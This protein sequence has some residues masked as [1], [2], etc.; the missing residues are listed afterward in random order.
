MSDRVLDASVILAVLF[1]EP[2]GDPRYLSDGKAA[3]SAVNFAEVV[4]RL[5]VAGAD[6]AQISRIL[7]PLG[8]EVID[9]D[10]Q[11][12]LDAGLLRPLTQNL[13]LSL[14]DRACLALARRLQL[15]ALTADRA[16]RSLS[17]GVDIQVTR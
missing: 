13:G 12:A 17:V 11:L 15:P 7:P 5:A 4:S 16:W 14:A 2:G 1:K 8:L 6:G 9:F 10:E 3:I